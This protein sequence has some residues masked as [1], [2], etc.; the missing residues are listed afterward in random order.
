MD[1]HRKQMNVIGLLSLLILFQPLLLA[2]A[3]TGI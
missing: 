2:K 3:N 1:T